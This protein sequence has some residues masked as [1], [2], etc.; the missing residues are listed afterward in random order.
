MNLKLQLIR[1]DEQCGKHFSKITQ[2]H[3]TF[4][5]PTKEKDA[6]QFVC[7]V[8]NESGK[9][10]ATFTVKFE[11]KK[12]HLQFPV[13]LTTLSSVWTDFQCLLARLLS[14]ANLRS[15]KRRRKE[16]SQPSFSISVF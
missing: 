9:L 5:E 2:L 4:Q 15:C 16:A 1:T 12:F 11:G 8:K 6:G 7:T 10:T 14:R 13:V 3:F